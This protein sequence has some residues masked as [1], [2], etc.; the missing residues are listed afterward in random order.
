MVIYIMLF[1]RLIPIKTQE[2]FLYVK[3]HLYR[4]ISDCLLKYQIAFYMMFLP[5]Y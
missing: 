2:H 3:E 1:D 5:W 4:K